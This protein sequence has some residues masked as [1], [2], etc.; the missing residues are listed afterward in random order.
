MM[1]R[2]ACHPQ[3]RFQS[4]QAHLGDRAKD[5][6]RPRLGWK[7]RSDSWDTAI[8]HR[9][10]PA[11]T[12]EGPHPPHSSGEVWLVSL[13]RLVSLPPSGKTSRVRSC[14]TFRDEKVGR[15]REG[16]GLTYTHTAG[17]GLYH[18]AAV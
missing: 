1:M 18:F 9:A 16:D 2:R 14:I 11:H 4:K 6:Q 8:V 15:L 3:R 5:P 12:Q 17:P 10:L 13:I 7:Q